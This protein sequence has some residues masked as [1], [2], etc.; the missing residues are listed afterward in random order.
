MDFVEFMFITGMI[1]GFF[2][3]MCFISDYVVP[4]V[5]KKVLRWNSWKTK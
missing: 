3:V 4:Y 5:E 1:C 2:S